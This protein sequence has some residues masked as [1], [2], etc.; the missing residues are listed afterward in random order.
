VKGDIGRLRS[1][2]LREVELITPTRVMQPHPAGH[3]HRSSPPSAITSEVGLHVAENSYELSFK[4]VA[5]DTLR[6]A[7]EEFEVTTS[8]G[9]TLIRCSLPDQAALYG[10]LDRIN[11]LG[12]E[13]L[14]VHQ[15]AAPDIVEPPDPTHRATRDR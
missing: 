14:D 13:L 3:D 9:L 4:G 8:R 1:K 7:F 15:V 12:L 6:A 5:S 2:A 11:A 10:L